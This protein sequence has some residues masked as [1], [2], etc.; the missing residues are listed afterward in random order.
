MLVV[1]REHARLLAVSA[2]R[3]LICDAELVRPHESKA[4]RIRLC[5]NRACR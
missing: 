4:R 3:T 2:R 1:V 5:D